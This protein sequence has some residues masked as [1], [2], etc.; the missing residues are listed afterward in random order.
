MSKEKIHLHHSA[1]VEK[2]K[3]LDNDIKQAYNR[4]Y[5]DEELHRMK[6]IKLHLKEEIVKIEDEIGKKEDG[7]R[8]STGH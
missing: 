2:H 3:T 5:K 6:K 7:K 8:I 1:L 4:H